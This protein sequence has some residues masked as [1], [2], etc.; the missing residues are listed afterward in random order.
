[1]NPKLETHMNKLILQI[2][3]ISALASTGASAAV[4]YQNS[5][6]Y[7]GLTGP[8]KDNAAATTDFPNG[9]SRNTYES[10]GLSHE[11]LDTAGGN[12]AYIWESSSSQTLSNTISVD[13]G[14]AAGNTYWL[15]ALLQWGGTGSTAGVVLSNELNVNPIGFNIASDG[16]VNAYG[17]FG[18]SASQN[19]DSGQMATA[20]ETH[21]M[22]LRGT[23]GSGTS[24]TDSV[25]DFWFD[26]GDVFNLGTPDW[27]SGATSKFGRHN[28]SSNF[29]GVNMFGDS[30]GGV[31]VIPRVD[32]INFTTNSGDIFV[33]PEPGTLA[34][35]GIALGGML[36]FRRR[37]A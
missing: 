30:S 24:P 19:N 34:L 20:G 28:S 18:G 11:N 4:L 35:V 21:L 23:V 7:G 10:T 37:G 6:E 27:A 3:L 36:L 9:S 32:E 1:M 25:L 5:L 26:P 14:F 15:A 31:S 17:S 2:V 13:P 8:W 22:V 12:Y 33:I 16:T 29:T